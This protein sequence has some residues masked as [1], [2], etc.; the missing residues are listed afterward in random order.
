MFYLI[1][2]AINIFLILVDIPDII[3]DLFHSN[4]KYIS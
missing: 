3:L 1:F 4:A 2:L